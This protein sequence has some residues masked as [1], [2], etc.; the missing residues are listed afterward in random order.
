MARQLD[1]GCRNM[2]LVS[3][4][5]AVGVLLGPQVIELQA[6]LLGLPGLDPTHLDG[7]DQ[8]GHLQGTGDEGGSRRRRE[9]QGGP[10]AQLRLNPDGKARR[11]LNGAIQGKTHQLH[12]GSHLISES[13]ACQT[14]H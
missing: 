11:K 5:D 14:P 7:V 2:H 3:A 8:L 6:A 10:P 9:K 4:Q 12:L 13:A 1:L